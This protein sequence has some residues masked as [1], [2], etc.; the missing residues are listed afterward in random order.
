MPLMR[1]KSRYLYMSSRADAVAVDRIS[2][3]ANTKL[4]T[5]YRVCYCY[6]N[7]GSHNL[8]PCTICFS[9]YYYYHYDP[10]ICNR[11]DNAQR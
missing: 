11:N 8:G 9:L 2:T 4:A 7:Y 6:M 10:S 5:W 1:A 3:T